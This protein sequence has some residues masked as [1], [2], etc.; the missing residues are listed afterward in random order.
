MVEACIALGSNLGA[1]RAFL[2]GALE[3]MRALGRLRAVSPLYETEPVGLR[4]QPPFLNAVALMDTA[5]EAR[6]LLRRL[7]EIE[8][9][10]GRVRREKDGPRTLDLDLLFYGG[11]VIREP[12]LEVPHPRLHERR[13]VLAPL[14]AVAPRWCHPLV[15]KTVTEMLGEL[16][17]AAGVL[18]VESAAWAEDLISP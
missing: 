10:H 14:A 7:L 3:E 4:R 15:G 1:R 18:E 9:R 13:F 8:A 2:R 6:G 5:L 16:E 17:D 11:E 12:G